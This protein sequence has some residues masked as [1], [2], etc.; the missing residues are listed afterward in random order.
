MTITE[1]VEAIDKLCE[2]TVCYSCNFSNICSRIGS[3]YELSED[4]LDKIIENGNK[5]GAGELFLTR[6][7]RI[8]GNSKQKYLMF[9]W[10]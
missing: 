1:K 6:D 3:L 8:D 9:Q 2:A 5:P 4:S 7:N 10:R